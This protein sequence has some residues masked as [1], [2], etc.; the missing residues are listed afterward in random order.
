MMPAFLWNLAG[1]F[2]WGV[3]LVA[4]RYQLERK[5][6]KKEQASALAALE[7]GMETVR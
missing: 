6:Q 1:W 5:R 3:L 2:C 7:A 4:L